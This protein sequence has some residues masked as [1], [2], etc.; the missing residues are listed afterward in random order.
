MDISWF[1]RVLNETI[2]CDA[3]VEN[4]CTRAFSTASTIR[5]TGNIFNSPDKA[6]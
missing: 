2:A 1:M 6:N 3:N 4:Y 5:V